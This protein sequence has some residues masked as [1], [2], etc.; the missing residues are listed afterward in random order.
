MAQLNWRAL[1]AILRSKADLHLS[2]YGIP[3]ISGDYII[4]PLFCAFDHTT[5][6]FFFRTT[7]DHLSVS[8]PYESRADSLLSTVATLRYLRRNTDIP[9]PHVF[10]FFVEG[11]DL[12]G[13]NRPWMII[14][15]LPGSPLR[16]KV[17]NIG[18]DRLER[19]GTQLGK[20]YSQLVELKFEKVGALTLQRGGKVAV[21]PVTA[22]PSGGFLNSVFYRVREGGRGQRLDVD[23][24][25]HSPG[26]YFTRLPKYVLGFPATTPDILWSMRSYIHFRN[27][28]AQIPEFIENEFLKPFL[29]LDTHAF[30]LENIHVDNEWNISGIIDWDG[31]TIK[32]IHIAL[33]L[34]HPLESTQSFFSPPRADSIWTAAPMMVFKRAFEIKLGENLLRIHAVKTQEPL[35]ER[36]LPDFAALWGSLAKAKDF[37]RLLYVFDGKQY[38]QQ[39]LW[40]AY[41]SFV[42]RGWVAVMG[43]ISDLDSPLGQHYVGMVKIKWEGVQ[44]QFGR[45]GL[46]NGNKGGLK[47]SYG[48]GLSRPTQL[49][50]PSRRTLAR[51][52]VAQSIPEAEHESDY[53]IG[54]FGPP[55]P[56]VFELPA[57]GSGILR[58]E[59]IENGKESATTDNG[60]KVE[61]GG[62]SMLG[63]MWSKIRKARAKGPQ[64]KTSG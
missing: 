39:H 64:A 8:A 30:D 41:C 54:I 31:T 47:R 51:N 60:K 4:V 48:R 34:P 25:Y 45:L 55:S 12:L 15:R 59:R 22:N 23:R 32:P 3:F 28:H 46:G 42:D 29:C 50:V 11:P 10:Y 7:W 49:E 24:P 37:E 33:Q 21:G 63:N 62:R 35:Y 9:V 13:I 16:T 58:I 20:L 17:V 27:L 56:T 43:E 14:E 18:M 2:G 5:P 1:A 57:A 52:V 19:I 38:G 26:A 36:K 53:E 44:A 40:R 6:S 61:G